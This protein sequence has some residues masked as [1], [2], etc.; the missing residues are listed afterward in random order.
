MAGFF[1]DPNK[2]LNVWLLS[3]PPR[4]AP[5]IWPSSKIAPLK[6]IFD[7]CQSSLPASRKRLDRSS[8]ACATLWGSHMSSSHLSSTRFPVPPTPSNRI[9]TR[10]R[11]RSI[12]TVITKPY[13][14]ILNSAAKSNSAVGS[15]PCTTCCG[16]LMNCR[17]QY[18]RFIRNNG[19]GHANH[20]LFWR[21]MGPDGCTPDRELSAA[22]SRD[23]GSLESLQSQ[24]NEAGMRVF[25]SGWVFVAITPQGK[26]ASVR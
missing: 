5:P 15:I 10:R 17:R 18:A 3:Q 26:L 11:W 22:I 12:T 24:F 19:G 4:G 21:I 6:E 1:T 13:V 16:R 2:A 8:L 25:G 7:V 23:V 14:A 9:S 20:T